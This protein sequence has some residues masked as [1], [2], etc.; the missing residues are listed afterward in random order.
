MFR[1]CCAQLPIYQVTIGEPNIYTEL[2]D[3]GITLQQPSE[4]FSPNPPVFPNIAIAG[5]RVQLFHPAN[6]SFTGVTDVFFCPQKK[7]KHPKLYSI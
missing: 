7:G 1:T 2:E 4:I 3:D 5:R 6:I